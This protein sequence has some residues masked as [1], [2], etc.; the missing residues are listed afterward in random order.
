M[1]L[2]YFVPGNGAVAD[3]EALEQ[4]GIGYAFED[5]T[6]QNCECMSGPG[7]SHGVL[8]APNGAKRIA[9]KPDEQTWRQVPGHE[10]YVGFWNDDRPTPESLAREGG[11]RGH[12]VEL[13]DGQSWQIPIAQEWLEGPQG[14]RVLRVLPE[15]ID[16]DA[17]GQWTGAGVHPAYARLW[18]YA[19]QYWDVWLAAL[20][21]KAQEVDDETPGDEKVVAEMEFDELMDAASCALATN[22][23]MSPLEI[24][25]LGLL[26][27]NHAHRVLEAVCDWDSFWQ[28]VK[29]KQASV[30][31]HTSNGAAG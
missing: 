19:V 5:S 12:V 10:S 28:I 8:V 1:H 20:V 2:L 25:L 4:N 24:G 16:V 14:A 31:L 29:K 13:A 18:E 17:N 11:V 7:G 21:G 30:A 23:R 6:Y 15:S 9:Y 3:R 26:T 22:Y 27:I